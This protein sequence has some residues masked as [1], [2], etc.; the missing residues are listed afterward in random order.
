[1]VAR[2]VHC[3]ALSEHVARPD[4]EANLQFVIEQ[5]RRTEGGKIGVVRFGLP[6]RPANRRAAGDDRTGAPV[7]PDRQILV[8]WQERIVGAKHRADVRR[9]MNRGV[10]IGIVADL[11]GQK[12]FD[13]VHRH[14]KLLAALVVIAQSSVAR[15]Q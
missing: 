13:L 14:K 8:V 7:I 6:H 11:R 1:M 10:E 15:L 4:K 12:T 2:L 9:M 3:D 5:S